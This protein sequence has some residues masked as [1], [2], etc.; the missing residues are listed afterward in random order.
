MHVLYLFAGVEVEDCPVI[1]SDDTAEIIAETKR[2][3]ATQPVTDSKPQT[4]P[5]Q[6][7]RASAIPQSDEGASKSERPVKPEAPQWKSGFIFLAAGIDPTPKYNGR[8]CLGVDAKVP[9]ALLKAGVCD[10]VVVEADG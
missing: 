5:E 3:F 1:L 6:E 2:L 8:R 10:L 7:A 4:V 9:L